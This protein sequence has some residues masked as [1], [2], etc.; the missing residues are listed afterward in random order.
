MESNQIIIHCWVVIF[1]FSLYATGRILYQFRS[2]PE[3]YILYEE[4][5]FDAKFNPKKIKIYKYFFLV[6]LSPMLLFRL[7]VSYNI[8]KVG[9]HHI[10]T[11]LQEQIALLILTGVIVG[12]TYWLLEFKIKSQS[13]GFIL[14]LEPT[15]LKEKEIL[16]KYEF[17]V[18]NEYFKC[19][20]DD[21][22]KILYFGN[23][24]NQVLW[25][26]PNDKGKNKDR[27]LLLS[28]LNDCLNN[29]IL[30]YNVTDNVKCNFINKYFKFD[31]FKDGNEAI[32]QAY[33]IS[34]FRK[35]SSKKKIDYRTNK[36]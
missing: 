4:V 12:C 21:F 3:H 15:R 6:F 33:T 13:K 14:E 28:F 23:I 34:D 26:K 18:E 7:S 30:Y 9:K 1:T 5:K 32:L 8:Y 29:Q 27:Q 22:K 2:I 17:A 35:N 16:K 11:S 20:L 19:E 24:D 25:D 31:E 10:L 36:G